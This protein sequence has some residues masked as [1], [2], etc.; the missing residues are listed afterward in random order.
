MTKREFIRRYPTVTEEGMREKAR[1]RDD[2]ITGN[3]GSAALRSFVL[4]SNTGNATQTLRAHYVSGCRIYEAIY[5]H[6]HSTEVV[7][8]CGVWSPLL[9]A[10]VGHGFTQED[11]TPWPHPVTQST[12][13]SWG[14][15][16]G[17]LGCPSPFT[18]EY[19][20]RLLLCTAMYNHG[21]VD[22][23]F[24]YA[25]AN[26]CDAGDAG[27]LKYFDRNGEGADRTRR[28]ISLYRGLDPALR[29]QIDS[30]VQKYGAPTGGVLGDAFKLMHRFHT[31]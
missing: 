15:L 25:I 19:T 20:R 13:L 18:D 8:L 26:D 30:L 7:R 9:Q 22:F 11:T 28:F 6:T 4:Q 2:L 10:M 16:W 31:Y 1:W 12:L 5:S 23:I 3:M 29:S 17:P 24:P 27:H 21:G 14:G